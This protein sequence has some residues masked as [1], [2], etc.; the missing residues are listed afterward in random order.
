MQTSA[1][2]TCPAKVNLS[3]AITGRRSDGFH[4]LVSVVCPISLCD[5]LHI[6]AIG[7]GAADVLSC[8]DASVPCDESNLVLKAAAALRAVLPDLP[9][10]RFRLEKRIPHGAGLGGGSSDAAAT[11]VALNTM[12]GGPLARPELAQLAS[13]LG[14]D[15][16]L[17]VDPQPRIMRGR[18]EVLEDLPP[19]AVEAVADLRFLLFKPPFG[20]STPWAYSALKALGDGALERPEDAEARL[21]RWIA[22][23]TAIE[24][25]LFNSLETPVFRKYLALQ[26]LCGQIRSRFNLPVLMSG[27]GS[28]CFAVLKPDS[29]VGELRTTI[30]DALGDEAFVAIVLSTPDIG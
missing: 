9:G 26:T 5:T 28:T 25:L 17:F 2:I 4:D 30:L 6:E 8:D 24:A 16:P 1:T 20:V 22:N 21:H 12:L 14:S 11:L 13:T 27:S 23:P 18:G 29:P 15:C 3:L 10:C 19:A 7:A